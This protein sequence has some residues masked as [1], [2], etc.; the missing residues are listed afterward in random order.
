[1]KL[2][3]T[4]L[5]TVL[6]FG[7]IL[8]GKSFANDDSLANYYQVLAGVY[9][10]KSLSSDTVQPLSAG[11]R[12][13]EKW[14][15]VAGTQFCTRN[16]HRLSV[17]DGVYIVNGPVGVCDNSYIHAPNADVCIGDHLVLDYQE[18]NL[19]LVSPE[20]DDC[21]VCIPGRILPNIVLANPLPPPDCPIGFIQPPGVTVCIAMNYVLDVNTK[22]IEP[23][24]PV[25]NINCPDNWQQGNSKQYCMPQLVLVNCGI[26]TFSCHSN[27]IDGFSVF[28]RTSCP[29]PTVPIGIATVTLFS[30]SE[31]G[32]G[33][34][35]KPALLCIPGRILPN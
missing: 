9:V 5:A 20:E 15:R 29:S 1:M 21:P 13:A 14:S 16:G 2:Y 23:E 18:E 3:T 25:P 32:L 19:R 30:D 17:L 8:S 22:A 28:E 12:C 4:K 34:T 10:E 6:L 35:A 24:I 31:N 27:A 11:N 7:V 33:L 26:D